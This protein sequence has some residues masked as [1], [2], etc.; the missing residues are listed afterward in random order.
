[1]RTDQVAGVEA[2]MRRYWIVGGLAVL[3]IVVGVAFA[4]AVVDGEAP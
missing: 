1:M 4:V 3:L 2:G